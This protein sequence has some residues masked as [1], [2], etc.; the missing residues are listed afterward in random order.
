[1]QPVLTADQSRAFDK[2]L[3]EE[4]GIPSLVLMENAARGSLDAIKDWLDDG[5]EI[6]VVCGLGNN[7]GDGL[8]LSRLLIERKHNVTTFLAGDREKLSRD[9]RAQY[10]ALSAILDPD[11][12]YS[13]DNAEE[14]LELAD[15]AGMVVDA[16]LGTGSKGVPTGVIAEGVRAIQSLQEGGAQ[17]LSID[18]P[19]GLNADAGAFESGEGAHLIVRADRTATM[20]APKVGFYQRESRVFTGDVTVVPLGAPYPNGLFGTQPPTYLVSATDVASQIHPFPYTSSKFTRGRILALCGSRGMSGAAIMSAS[21]ALKSGAGYVTVGIPHSERQIVAQAMPELL[22]IGIAEQADGSP[23]LAAWEDVKDEVEKSDVVLIGCGYR[24]FEETAA[25]VRKVVLEVDKPMIID[26]GALRSIAGHFDILRGRTAPTILTP[27]VG[28]LAALAER[29]RADVERN[30]LETAREVATNYSATVV[31]K[32]VPEYTVDQDGTTYINTTGNPGM[33]TAGTGDVLAGITATMLAQNPESPGMAAMTAV[34]LDGLAGD[35][36][37][38]EKTM[39]GMTATD[40]IRM[41]PSAFKKL[42]IS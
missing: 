1:M 15:S 40:V 19:T 17:I 38:L 14:I 2:Y 18:I 20:G 5:T 6:V 8:A 39:H 23:S 16:L 33:G 28:E 27:N 32:G 41:L 36:A 9:A 34:Y 30:L 12:I 13:F 7:G 26:G 3:T 42:G 22:T 10:D 29:P 35:F 37:A 11:E 24:Q 4:I 21:A 31:A 25:F